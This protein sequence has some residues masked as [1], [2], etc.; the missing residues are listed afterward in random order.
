M[1]TVPFTLVE[2]NLA[3]LLHRPIDREKDNIGL[4]DR[5]VMIVVLA[6]SLF[7]DT[8]IDT[9]DF[10]VVLYH[11]Y[12][13]E[14]DS[15]GYLFNKVANKSGVTAFN[16]FP[17]LSV[18]MPLE[19]ETQPFNL[20]IENQLDWNIINWWL[21]CALIIAAVVAFIFAL[22]FAKAYHN[23]EL[24]RL[25][26]ADT[27]FYLANHDSLTGLA[28]RSLMLDRLKHAIGQAERNVSKLAVLFMDLNEF[29]AINDNYGHDAGDN[30]LR[31]VAERLR[32][33]MRNG[34]TLARRSG[35]EFVLV[36]ENIESVEMVLQV[37][38][39][40]KN[41]FKE[42]FYVHQSEKNMSISIGFAI[43]PDDA[44]LPN[45]LLILADKRMY[46]N[47]GK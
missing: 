32:A 16:L 21:L 2:G 29:K 25:Q 40:I 42:S 43:F 17:K 20:L 12:F 28:N 13:K 5:Y 11:R 8:N 41:A 3:Y 26:E 19:S 47:K 1:A 15:K 38:E 36:L 7:E 9:L 22:K 30:L 46:E 31:A 44:T 6:K 39:K 14:G 34:D 27:L 37:V 18:T 23:T 10:D 4:S 45:E 24:T 33:C 35:D